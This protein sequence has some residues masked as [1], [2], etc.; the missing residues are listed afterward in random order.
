MGWNSHEDQ[1]LPF[2]QQEIPSTQWKPT[3]GRTRF[4]TGSS[5]HENYVNIGDF[6]VEVEDSRMTVICDT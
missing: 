5:Y 2:V 6:N 3:Y 4:F 1:I